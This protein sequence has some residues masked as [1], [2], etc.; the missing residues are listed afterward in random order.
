MPERAPRAAVAP[1][2]REARSDDAIGEADLGHRDIDDAPAD[3]LT[4]ERQ[5]AAE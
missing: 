3:M 1:S 2:E 4:C 5:R